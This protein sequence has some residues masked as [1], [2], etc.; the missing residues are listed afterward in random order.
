M[1]DDCTCMKEIIATLAVPKTVFSKK[2]KLP[3]N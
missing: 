1:T 3:V 2:K